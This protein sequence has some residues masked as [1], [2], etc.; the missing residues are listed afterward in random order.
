[1][2][3]PPRLLR[4]VLQAP[5]RYVL[6][7]AGF[8]ALAIAGIAVGTVAAAHHVSGLSDLAGI[9][10]GLSLALVIGMLSVAYNTG[11]RGPSLGRQLA[12]MLEAMDAGQAVSGRFWAGLRD[13]VPGSP[14]TRWKS[15]RVVI[16]PQ[17]VVW[18]RSISGR[19][20]ELTGAECTRE[21]RPDRAYREM[22]LTVPSYCKGENLRVITLDASGINVELAAPARLLE[23]L[24]YSLARTPW[25]HGSGAG[26][27]AGSP[28]SS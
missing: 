24:R 25:E 22:S 12:A 8:F 11:V 26:Q 14:L 15:G 1:V 7:A 17:S 21:R 19:A 20:R 9:V 13:L 5:W 18:V 2:R 16:T 6:L 28:G 10:V 4:Y 27:L 3:A 23:I